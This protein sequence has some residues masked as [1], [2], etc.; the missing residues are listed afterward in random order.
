MTT[1][2]DE[3]G[4]A[5]EAFSK[6]ELEAQLAEKLKEQ[7]PPAPQADLS[8]VLE[9]LQKTESALYEMRVE[10]YAD[11]HAGNDAEKREKFMVKFGRLTGYE[12]TPEGIAER[13]RDAAKLAFDATQDAST[14]G[15]ADT[16]GRSVDTA[17]QNFAPSNDIETQL[18]REL[19]ISDTDVEKYGKKQ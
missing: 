3:Q 19:G 4:N 5:V 7:T 1:Y 8:P 2:Y 14:Q 6:E 12:E 15:L 17:S 13:A 16:G 10:K 18:R 11:I 9:R